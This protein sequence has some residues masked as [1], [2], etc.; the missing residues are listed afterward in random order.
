LSLNSKPLPLAILLSWSL[1][2]ACL[3]LML[4]NAYNAYNNE[5]PLSPE[6]IER[7]KQILQSPEIEARLIATIR[8]VFFINDSSTSH[9]I[10]VDLISKNGEIDELG[11]F[12][13]AAK[14]R[15]QLPFF[16]DGLL[17][18]TCNNHSTYI[19]IPEAHMKYY[20]HITETNAIKTYSEPAEEMKNH[21]ENETWKA[22]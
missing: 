5:R 14:Q 6:E 12:E 9:L 2:L 3:T 15:G 4:Y 18:I 22:A 11:P 19:S 20:F 13:I 7:L 10:D 8:Q 21:Q 17:R 1:L 16:V